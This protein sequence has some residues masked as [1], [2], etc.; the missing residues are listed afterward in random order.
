MRLGI[1]SLIAA[2]VFSQFYRAFLAVMTPV[3][4]TEI[5]V[6]AEDMAL[7]S[8][9]WFLAFAALQ[10]PVGVALDSLGP[11]RTAVTLFSIGGA[12]GAILFATA[13][14]A[15]QIQLAMALIGVGCAPVLMACYFIFA[16]SF[17]PVRFGALAGMVVGIGSLGNIAGSA[18]L[19]T[20]I[21]MIGWRATLWGLAVLTL[22]IAALMAVSIKDPERVVSDA[23]GSVLGLLKLPALWPILAMMIVCY[24]PG[25]GLRGLWLGPYYADVF[26]ANVQ[27]IGRVTLVMG[28]AMVLGTFLYGPLERILGTRK[29]L[30]FG[31]NM[32]AAAGFWMLFAMPA[33]PGWQGLAVVALIGLAGS[34]YP[35]VI[36]HGRAFIPAHLTGRGVALLN[37]FGIG[38][39]GIAQMVTGRLHGAVSTPPP[40]APYQ[41]LFLFYAATI[42]LGCLIYLTSKDRTD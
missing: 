20:L 3:L 35:M 11:R 36:G 4:K 10:I 22:L 18:P 27:G 21:G 40:E 1:A 33:L 28:L 37:L 39:A 15:L 14:S 29:W 38:S 17:S 42:T 30:I 34:S 9:L 31:G 16:R 32:L 13:N 25:A 23:K 8:G 24:M 2:Y 6:S 41:A 19:A 26:G 12:G 7:A 5:G